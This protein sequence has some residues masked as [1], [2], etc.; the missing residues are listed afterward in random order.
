MHLSLTEAAQR[1][2]RSPRQVRYAIK[3]GKLKATKRAGRWIIDAAD[4]PAASAAVAQ[5]QAQRAAA[6]QDAVADALAPVARK[7]RGY[8]VGDLR[9]F[10][11][12]ASL[13]VELAAREDASSPAL[14]ALTECVRFLARG[15]HAWGPRAKRGAW[16][17]ARRAG[18][19][20]VAWLF[21]TGEDAD[22][23]FAR[24][25]EAEVLVPLGSLLGR[26]DRSSQ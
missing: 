10:R 25:V 7:A 5:R 4:L 21:M 6:V 8:S 19:D 22:E 23:A 3:Q 17:D 18:S 12:A 14:L 11:S 15:G 24:R 13:R 20:A 1:L 16:L 2:G 26:L 9:A